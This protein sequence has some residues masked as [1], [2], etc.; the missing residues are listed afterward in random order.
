[1]KIVY[2]AGPLTTGWDGKDREFLV[3]KIKA[4]EEYGVV[5]ANNGIGF[6][7]SHS[8][9]SFHREKGSIMPEDF[10]YEL[11][12]EFLKR[13]ADALLA[14]PGWEASN[15]AKMEVEIAKQMNLPVFYTQSPD[16]IGEIIKWANNK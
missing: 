4:A 13:S 1:M 9:T 2:I 11:G 14:M 6:F 7:C 5:L 10:Y 3:N 16:D 8:H 15:G 12:G